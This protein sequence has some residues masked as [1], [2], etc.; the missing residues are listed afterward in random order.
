MLLNGPN[1][2][3]QDSVDSQSSLTIAQ[4]ILFNCKKRLSVADTSRHNLNFE[5][6]L[7]MY[8]GMKI[9]TQ[10]R[11]KK[12]VMEMNELGLSISYDRLLQLE[13]QLANSVCAHA[14]ALG[15]VCPSTLRCGL[16]TASALD[17]LDHNPS[18]T[19]ATDA[20]HGTGIS[21]FQSCTE[22]N[23]GQ[24]QSFELSSSSE[25][26]DRHLPESYTVVPAVALKK[27][28]VS[29]PK[30]CNSIASRSVDGQLEGAKSQEISWL[31]HAEK[32]LK[33]CQLECTDTITWAAY[34]ASFVT[35]QNVMPALSQLMPVFY[36]KAATA[37]MV[38]HGMTVQQKA[39]QHLNP[40]QIPV[41]AFDAPLFALA[42]LVQWKWPTTHGE[43]KHVVMLGGLHIEMAMWN[44]FGDYLEGSG[45]TNAL[46]QAN[47]ASCGT[48]DS[49]LKASH[50][51]RTRHGHQVSLLALYTLQDEAF[52]SCTDGPHNAETKEAWI[53]NMVER[54]PTFQYWNTVLHFELLGLIFVRAHRECNFSL[55]VESLKA[56]A[57]WFFA[58]DHH[59]Y[60]RWLPVHI[61]DME[62]LPLSIHREFKELGHW[63]ISKTQNR[64]SAMP[65]DQA[66][67][68]NNALV[69]GSGGAI[70]LTE[71]PSAFRKWVIAG[72]EQARLIVEFERQF[73]RQI[74]EKHL[75]HEEGL[76][77]QNTFKQQVLGLVETMNDLGNP[78]LDH[79]SELLKLD[80]RDVMNESLIET[81]RTVESLGKMKYMEYRESVTLKCERS[82]HDTISKNGLA[83]FKHPKA[84]VKTKQAKAVATLKDDVAL[85]SRLYIVAR[86]RECDMASFFQHENQSFPPSISEYGKLRFS[87]KSDLLPLLAQNDISS[88][89]ESF[90]VITFDGGA[91]VHLLSTANITTFDQYADNVVIPHILMQLERCTRVSA[92]QA[93][94]DIMGLELG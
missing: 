26:K 43:D 23:V 46:T 78:F 49:F 67:E 81:V 13:N 31:Q 29:V 20:F 61:R 25:I 65:V 24:L 15:L 88:H 9:H 8:V 19:T 74:Q 57:P 52:L 63:V 18:S 86:N 6:P 53:R 77:A 21:L 51:T 37:A 10:T 16:F 93:K 89:P 42:K 48:A 69:K 56:L 7:P 47:I 92:K 36:E 71:N 38:K 82:I 3:D 27:E 84:R 80:T 45:W 58:L 90:D 91:L 4:I 33:K 30:G 55:Y 50:L 32:L 22:S 73:S 76:S 62:N 60:A 14:N 39:I 40:G 35:P 11:S 70:G 17:N 72:P 66:H 44:T 5:P 54:S 2:K 94:S 41:T 83:L 59:N 64:F 34:H 87:K 28:S 79:S 1:I 85:F 12:L 68:Q 75:H